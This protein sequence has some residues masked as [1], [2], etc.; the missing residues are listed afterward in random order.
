MSHLALVSLVGYPWH[1]LWVCYTRTTAV[2]LSRIR[3]VLCLLFDPVR[4]WLVTGWLL[5]RRL[6]LRNLWNIPYKLN[7][8]S[9]RRK[10]ISKSSGIT[11]PDARFEIHTA[12]LMKSSI[13][14]TL[15][16]E[17]CL[18]RVLSSE[19]WHKS[20]AYEEF[21]LLNSNTRVVLM[22]SSVFWTLTQELCLWRVLSSELWHKSCAYEEHYLLNSDTRAVLK[23]VLSSEL[24]HKSYAY[25]EFYLLNSDTRAVFMKSSVFWTLTQELCLWRVLSSELWQKSCAYEE[26]Y[27]LNSDTRAVLMKSSIFWTPTQELCLWRVLP[28]ELW[29]KSCAYEEFYLLNSDTRAVLMKSSTFWTLTQELCFLAFYGDFLLLILRLWRCR[30]YIPPIHLVIINGTTALCSRK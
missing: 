2:A 7:A 1:R 25:E 29:H 4:L 22:N 21:Y 17:L 5:N 12:V 19:L 18:W 27:L 30:Q 24:W 28:S 23:T 11:L 9:R 14:W 3:R 15:T 13:F 6:H 10:E 26:F 16:Q 8:E 20:C